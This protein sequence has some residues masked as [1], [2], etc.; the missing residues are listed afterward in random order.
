MILDAHQLLV[1]LAP[2]VAAA[3]LGGCG[4]GYS[5]SGPAQVNSTVSNLLSSVDAIG[6][7]GAGLIS[8]D[9]THQFLALQANLKGGSAQLRFSCAGCNISV[10]AAGSTVGANQYVTIPFATLDSSSDATITVTDNVSGAIATYTLRARP[11]DHPPYTVGTNSNPEPG[12]LYLTPFDPQGFAAPYAYIVASDGSLK[13]YYRNRPGLKIHDF[14]KTIIPGGA[15]RYSFYDAADSAIRV[16]DAG[17]NLLAKVTAL[18]FPDGNTYAVDLHDHVILDD[19]HYILGVYAAKTVSNIPALPGQSLFVSGA[20][21]QEIQNGVAVFSWLSTDHPELYACSTSHNDFAANNGADYAHWNSVMVDADTNW[22]A[23]FK[24]LDAVLK[25]RRSDGAVDWIL[26]GPC[27]QFG[28]SATQKFSHQ[29][30]ARRAADGRLTVF[31]DNNADGNSRALAFNLDEATKTL[32]TTN[33]ALPGFAAFTSDAHA[34]FNLGS[35]QLFA[36]GK[37]LVGW[38]EFLGA[39][40][41]VSEFDTASGALSFQLTLHP[42]A[43][44]NGYFSYRAQKFQ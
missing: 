4:G 3:V 19:G 41:D 15:I 34:S 17:F 39:A 40:S 33:P 10:A 37:V 28:L 21:L 38:G 2:W 13:Y 35:A 29:H 1:R 27:D 22:I 23:S 5:S 44:S 25:I 30:H 9:P 32:V 11:V 12:D 42:S 31:D 20:G 16:M 24:Y 43:Y 8:N 14:K 18:P 36:D 26:G 6:V 7:G